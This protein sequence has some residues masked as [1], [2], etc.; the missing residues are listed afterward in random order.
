MVDLQL[1]SVEHG[2]LDVLLFGYVVIPYVGTP[3][4]IE[5]DQ[6]RRFARPVGS[7]IKAEVDKL[8]LILVPSFLH[9]IGVP[10]SPAIGT[11]EI[12][13]AVVLNAR[14]AYMGMSAEME[15]INYAVVL[16]RLTATCA[17][18]EEPICAMV[19]VDV[20]TLRLMLLIRWD[21]IAALATRTGTFVAEELLIIELDVIPQL[22]QLVQ[23]DLPATL[24]AVDQVL[25]GVA[26]LHRLDSNHFRFFH[27]SH[28]LSSS[29]L[30]QKRSMRKTIPSAAAQIT[31]NATK[32]TS[33]TK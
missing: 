9:V 1:H 3:V 32:R 13:G 7:A 22:H 17:L 14:L 27:D 15:D 26:L 6:I 10:I 11:L 20:A 12:A 23:V 18:D 33:V 28:S 24:S 5:D 8:F 29:P 2:F 4:V 30:R 19:A 21:E 16:H 25:V 31:A